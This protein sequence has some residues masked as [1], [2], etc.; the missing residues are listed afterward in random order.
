MKKSRL[1]IVAWVLLC[2][3]CA[4]ALTACEEEP[5]APAH[6][7]TWG[8]WTES[9][10]AT[11]TEQ[12]VQTHVCACGQSES[13][14]IPALGH[15]LDGRESDGTHHWSVCTRTGCG[16]EGDKA[17]H[18]YDAEN[19]CSCSHY[20]DSGV[21]FTPENGTYT[22]TDYTGTA[23][24]V[25]IPSQYKGIAVTGIGYEAFRGYTDLT[26]VTIPD[27]V[28]VIGEG[29]FRSCTGL[30]AVTIPDSVTSIGVG[31]FNSCVGLTS[32]TIPASVTSVGYLAF[33]NCAGLESV[34]VESGN[35]QYHSA[36]NCLIETA[37]GTLLFG[38]KNSVIPTDG[39]VTS[40]E[41]YAFDRCTGL[42]AVT[43]PESVTRIGDFVFSQ[44]TGLT[45]IAIP[46]SVTSIG[47]GAF[48]YS[49]GLTAITIPDSVTSVG[50]F[51][52][53]ECTGLISVTLPEGVT[54][55]GNY[56]FYGCVSLAAITVPATVT[57][58]G[59]S[60][61]YG[62]N[63]LAGVTF[64]NP[65]GWWRASSSTATGGTPILADDLSDV[66]DAATLLKST[67]LKYYWK[68]T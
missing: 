61:F 23:S 1:S 37:T 32:V 39:S 15:L 18:V 26:A 21:E 59:H 30:T 44:C 65:N 2:L 20:K 9:T 27:S 52:F 53:R 17:P 34:T 60:A 38:C 3:V 19:T 43:I 35:A 6:T 58:I 36:G 64:V 33:Y 14:Y 66:T 13:E 4:L 31:A 63:D 62:C 11:C 50:N 10:L 55:I 24:L 25:I 28:T 22:V 48:S 46:D 51:V 68:R 54:S 45:A 41:N 7:H 47:N 57:S 56:A 12:G 29:A 42:T 67:Y 49:T 5:E 40:I 16:V 8:E